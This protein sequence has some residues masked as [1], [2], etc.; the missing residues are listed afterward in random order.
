MPISRRGDCGAELTRSILAPLIPAQ[1]GIQKKLSGHE[2]ETGS[3]LS[4]G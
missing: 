1:A 4:R 3:P 2:Q